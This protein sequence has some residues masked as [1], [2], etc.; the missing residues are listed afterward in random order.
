[1]VTKYKRFSSTTQDLNQV[2]LNVELWTNQFQVFP[3]TDAK[4][5]SNLSLII[6][7]NLIGHGLGK[8]YTSCF[9]CVPTTGSS[10]LKQVSTYQGQAVDRSQYFCL[11]S[12]AAITLD[13][14]VF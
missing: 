14:V 6:G 10:T 3:L 13:I 2:Q 9:P 8:K 4:V 7:D 1:M 5:L 11:N 12:S